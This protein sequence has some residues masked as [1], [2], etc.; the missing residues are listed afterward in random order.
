[1]GR[2]LAFAL[3]VV[4]TILVVA[5]LDRGRE[6]NPSSA[7]PLAAMPSEPSI[8]AVGGGGAPNRSLLD[9]L[10]SVAPAG[11]VPA[12]PPLTA[13]GVEEIADRVERLRRLRFDGPVDVRFLTAEE[14]NRQVSGLIDEGSDPE[15]IRSRGEALELL[16]AI[17]PGA[18]LLGLTRRA[19]DSQV[20]GLFVPE[21]QE[22]LVTRS[23][24]AGAIEAITVAHELEHALADDALG[25]PLADRPRPGRGD[26]DLAALALV[27][28]DAT[29]AMSLY[30]GRYVPAGEQLSLLGDPA[31]S[32]GQ[33]ELEELPHII[34]AQLIFPYEAG[35]GYVCELYSNGGWKAVDRAYANPPGST[36]EL[37]DPAAGP[38]RTSEPEPIPALGP[39]WRRTLADQIGAAELSWLFE[40]PGDD[41]DAAIPD[42]AGSASDWRGGSIALWQQGDERALGVSLAERPGGSLCEAIVAWYGAANPAARL[43]RGDDGTTTF[44]DSHRFATIGCAEGG[45]RL[46]IGPDP[47]SAQRLAAG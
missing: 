35:L 33:S 37:L 30:A 7:R 28:G 18:G 9:C 1:M 26:R 4:G 17:P 31:V 39:P 13:R 32:S 21:T 19:L 29:L 12:S 20:L 40:A 44:S 27:E 43:S 41:P 10:S 15:L 8:D 42:A 3:A 34:Q 22:L 36:A 47:E 25:L 38:V 23:G 14:I 16:G 2:P 5:L 11:S 24:E 46:G 6:R 45:V